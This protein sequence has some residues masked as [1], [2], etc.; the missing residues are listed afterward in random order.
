M[1]SRIIPMEA[2]GYRELLDGLYTSLTSSS[3]KAG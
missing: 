1:L 3:Y 2:P